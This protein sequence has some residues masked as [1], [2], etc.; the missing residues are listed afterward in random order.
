[1]ASARARLYE[2]EGLENSAASFTNFL[3][4]ID[5]PPEPRSTARAA[6]RSAGERRRQLVHCQRT[7]RLAPLLEPDVPASSDASSSAPEVGAD[8]LTLI[9]TIRQDRI[10]MKA[11][12]PAASMP[13]VSL[14]PS[15][16]T[17]TYCPWSV[18]LYP[19]MVIVRPRRQRDSAAAARTTT[20]ADEHH[21]E[22][23]R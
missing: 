9:K 2:R 16:Q 17:A 19:P 6:V 18:S 11:Y 23:H 8:Q 15:R 3:V 22:L 7:Y 5:S 1:M 12:P 4:D 14:N 10:S 21:D 13:I 20:S